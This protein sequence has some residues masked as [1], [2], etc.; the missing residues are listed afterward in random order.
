MKQSMKKI[1]AKKQYILKVHKAEFSL[2]KYNDFV[3]TF[4]TL[5]PQTKEIK[6]EDVEE[7]IP[8]PTSL[9]PEDK[10]SKD[11]NISDATQA[12][13]QMDQQDF[14]EECS[15]SPLIEQAEVAQAQP[16]K[17]VR[18]VPVQAMPNI[19][20]YKQKRSGFYMNRAWMHNVMANQIVNDPKHFLGEAIWSCVVDLV[21]RGLADKITGMFIDQSSDKIYYD[22]KSYKTFVTSIKA[23]Y[24]ALQVSM[25]QGKA[26]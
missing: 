17:I 24:W 19:Q 25:I 13:S 9:I 21:G 5:N 8:E 16:V 18:F 1:N 14:V 4:K 23:C 15:I 10:E 22:M 3:N 7:A 2:E 11:D 26:I 12:T 20:N 6:V